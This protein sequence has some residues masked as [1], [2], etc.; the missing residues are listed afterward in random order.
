MANVKFFTG[1][2]QKISEAV[3]KGTIGSGGVIFTS[4]TDEL[5]LVND[6]KEERI[7]KSKTQDDYT[8]VGTDIGALSEGATIP[9]GTSIDELLKLLTQKRIA[10]TYTA[11]KVSI[12]TAGGDSTG[13]YEIGTEVTLNKKA[14]Y[15]QNDGGEATG[16]TFYVNG[17]AVDPTNVTDNVLSYKTVLTGDTAVKVTVAYADGPVKNDNFGEASPTGQIKAG[18]VSATDG[19]YYVYRKGF[20]NTGLGD[21]PEFT[22]ASVRAS[23]AWGLGKLTGTT[24]TVTLDEG[25]QYLYFAV[26]STTPAKKIMY[27][28]TNDT[29]MLGSFDQTSVEVE[30]ANGYTAATYTV[31][32]Y[33]LAVPAAATMTFQITF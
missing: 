3:E 28:E 20:Y 25:K 6:S 27:V 15:T 11:P 29:G 24:K 1:E 32:S 5:I 7:I 2:K 21:L 16:Y 30:G 26:P 18:T 19:T 23:N 4:D 33:R 22:S 13:S 17:S 14:T 10:A 8:L 12:G 31:Y 9:A